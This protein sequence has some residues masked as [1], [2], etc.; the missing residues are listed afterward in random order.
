MATN[1]VISIN[2]CDIAIHYA[3]QGMCDPVFS[4]DPSALAARDEE[5]WR[6]HEAIWADIANPQQQETHQ[7]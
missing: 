4:L 7:Q 3:C 6:R 1:E 2:S 5:Y